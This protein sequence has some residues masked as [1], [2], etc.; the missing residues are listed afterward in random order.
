MTDSSTPD[1]P[2]TPSA[3]APEAQ[4]AIQRNWGWLLALGIVWTVLGLA[5]LVA[6][7]AASI[8]VD[9][10]IGILL[11][12]GGGLQIAQCFDARDWEGILWHAIGGL[13]AL[14]VGA[15]LLLFPLRGVLSLTLLLGVFFLLD[16]LFKL[17][18]IPQHDSRRLRLWLGVSGGL[19]V[20]VAILI[21][22]GWPGSAAWA[23]GLLVGVGL[24]FT[25]LSMIVWS[26]EIRRAD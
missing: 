25:G 21:W 16:G 10:L 19:S 14:A 8:A 15:L 5:A 22:V 7:L 26:L 24:I 17:F 1:P 3:L 23:L 11:V 4:R 2:D 13:F 12:V 20:L 18:A 9:I 6:P